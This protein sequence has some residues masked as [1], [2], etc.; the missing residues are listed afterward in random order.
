MNIKLIIYL[1]SC[2]YGRRFDVKTQPKIKAQADRIRHIIDNR[3]TGGYAIIGSFAV[4]AEM[5]KIRNAK[6]LKAVEKFY[7][8]V[9][10]SEVN[11]SAQTIAR[12]TE[13]NLMGLGKMDSFHL[14]AAEAALADFLLTTDEDFVFKCKNRNLTAVK[15]INPLEF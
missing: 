12:A 5:R 9:I 11:I 1:D 7:Y 8:S 2:C 13:L 6:K 15:V 4:T 10:T 14:A 3:T